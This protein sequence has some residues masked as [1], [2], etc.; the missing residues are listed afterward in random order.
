MILMA[1]ILP[2]KSSGM[3]P[4]LRQALEQRQLVRVWRENMEHGSFC[5]YVGGVGR[6][7]FL[8]WVLGD[9]LSFDGLYALRHRD[10]TEIEAPDTH[11]KFLE[12]ALALND[13]QPDLPRDFAL[14]DTAGVVSSAT[15]HSPVISVHVDGED[16][17]DICYIG[18]LVAVEDDGFNLQEVTPDATWLREPSFFA[19][20]E[21]ST[22]SCADPYAKALIQVAGKPPEL[23]HGDSGVGRAP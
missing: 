19:W 17:A 14:D 21:V 18:R 22:V 11:H 3:R 9:N 5:G 4:L 13:I 23:Q 8:L 6:E 20:E 16:E 12:K 10:V 15:S 1:D 2:F 7:F